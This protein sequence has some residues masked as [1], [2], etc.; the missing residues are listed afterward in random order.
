MSRSISI[1]IDP[2]T[3]SALALAARGEHTSPE[4]YLSHMLTRLFRTLATHQGK[5]TPVITPA[6]IRRRGHQPTCYPLA[7]YEP[8]AAPE[9]PA[10]ASFPEPQP[11]DPIEEDTMLALLDA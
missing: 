2:H 8:P 7:A 1:S 5:E 11:M 4:S 3:A 10:P 6:N 9:P